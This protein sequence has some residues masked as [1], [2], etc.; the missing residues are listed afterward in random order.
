[1]T[2]IRP[3]SISG[4]TS[5]TAQVSDITIF[6]AS[7]GFANITAGN[8]SAAGT[9][10]YEDVT[11]IDSVGVVTARTGI[12]I[13]PSAG[14][15]GTF[16]ADGSYV[17]AGIIT[18]TTFHGSGA[19]LTSLPAQ[20]T[21]SNNADNR[22]ITGGSGVALNGES[23]LTWDG[24]DL[25]VI[26]GNTSMRLTCTNSA[27]TLNFNANNVADAGRITLS[28]SSGG[29]VMRFFTKTT[30]GSFA[31]K[32]RI[33]TEGGISFNGDTAAANALDD[34]EEGTWTP[35]ITGKTHSTQAGHYTKVGRYVTCQFILQGMN[36][37]QS[38]S[39]EISGLPFQAMNAN[40]IGLCQMGD[41][42]G[43]TYTS[44]YGNIYGRVNVSGSIVQLLE[45]K[46][47]GTTHGPAM[48]LQT[49]L[50][51]RGYIWYMTP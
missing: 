1:M 17:T 47:D 41:V 48:A 30:G 6:G 4:V 45:Q 3:N 7:S 34:Y 13:G 14:V 36:S 22:V 2:V 46:T 21:I 35:V 10:T 25:D 18:A 11:N 39:A 24:F 20:A 16:F 9:I 19:N 31:E 50:T 5:I 40:Q 51:L 37:T 33:Q 44:G 23:N 43:V 38:S 49:N 32:V 8:I 42:T 29:G 26:R 12:K 15:A 27:P 28:E